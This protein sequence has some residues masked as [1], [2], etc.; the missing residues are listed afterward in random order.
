MHTVHEDNPAGR[1]AGLCRQFVA[2]DPDTIAS[3][4]WSRV[5]GTSDRYDLYR[6]LGDV[7]G[8]LSQVVGRIPQLPPS[9]DP[10]WTRASANGSAERGGA[11]SM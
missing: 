1:L 11:P 7:V 5:L 6:Q 3:E 8:L 4:A 2:Q 9:E 10:D